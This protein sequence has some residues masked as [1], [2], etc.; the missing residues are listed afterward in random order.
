MLRYLSVSIDV[1]T[2]S[3]ADQRQLPEV[4][5]SMLKSIMPKVRY[6]EKSE[7]K[8]RLQLWTED[9]RFQVDFS[10]CRMSQS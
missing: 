8:E 2:A 6:I 1:A 7:Q 3:F 4:S 5:S 9:G 10:D